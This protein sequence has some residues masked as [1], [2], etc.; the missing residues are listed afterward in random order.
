MTKFQRGL[1]HNHLNARYHTIWEAYDRP[2]YAK[3]KAYE[4]CVAKAERLGATE[5]AI[6]TRNTFQFTFSAIYP[7][8]ETGELRM[9]YETARKSYDFPI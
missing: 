9:M 6:P 7:D 4:D 5:W 3:E 1:Y 8:A 2:S